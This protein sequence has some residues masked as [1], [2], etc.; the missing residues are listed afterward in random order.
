MLEREVHTAAKL[1]FL[2]EFHLGEMISDPIIPAWCLWESGSACYVWRQLAALWYWQQRLH[3]TARAAVT[4][5]TLFSLQWMTGKMEFLA[6]LSLRFLFCSLVNLCL[7]GCIISLFL[8]LCHYSACSTAWDL[9]MQLWT[10]PVSSLEY[11]NRAMKPMQQKCW[12]YYGPGEVLL[13]FSSR[14]SLLH[15]KSSVAAGERWGHEAG[16]LCHCW[17]SHCMSRSPSL[18]SI[19][20][21]L[22]RQN[23]KIWVCRAT[24]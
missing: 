20:S 22:F 11:L 18:P 14:R 24:S 6:T 17:H 7:P 19:T 23:P 9:S 12:L 2:I 5:R 21:A 15:H 16:R 10:W 3:Q 1:L 8:Q 4:I 13:V